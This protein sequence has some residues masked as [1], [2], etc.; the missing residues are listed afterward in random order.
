MKK[1]VMLIFVTVFTFFS[2]GSAE[3]WAQSGVSNRPAAKNP[4]AKRL[5]CQKVKR[6]LRGMNEAHR[7]IMS[8]LSNSYESAAT[9]LSGHA[10][11]LEQ[12][13]GQPQGAAEVDTK[14][15]VQRMDDSVRAF[16]KAGEKTKVLVARYAKAS[17]ELMK[18]VEK[19][20]I[21]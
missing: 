18:K 7:A 3:S 5:Y 21:N 13:L 20:M 4:R 2:T 6:E 8:S 17:D 12:D 19:C 11:N 9:T 1:P 16:R 15:D 10:E 14:G